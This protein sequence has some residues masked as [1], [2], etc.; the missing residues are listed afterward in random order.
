LTEQLINQTDTLN[1]KLNLHQ[2]DSVFDDLQAE[3]NALVQRSIA[4]TVFS[5]LEWQSNWWAAYQPGE[6]WVITVRDQT[7][8]LIGIAPW[9]IET[10]DDGERVIRGI[11]CVDVTD[12]VDCIVDRDCT[13]QVFGCF[14]GYLLEHSDAYDRINLCNIPH[15]SPT[16]THFP[17]VL[18]QSNFV[19]E[20]EQQEVCPVITLPNDWEGYLNLLD[21]KQRH[22]LRRKLRRGDTEGEITWYTVNES[23]DL[24]QQLELFLKLMAESAPYKAEFLRDKKN[25]AFFRRVM[26]AMFANGWL[27][28]N[29]LTIDGVPAATYLN[30]DYDKRVMVYNSGLSHAFLNASPG[31][32]LLA[33]N[34]RYAIEN[35]YTAFDFLRGNEEYKYRMG[36]SDQPVYMLRAVVEGKSLGDGCGDC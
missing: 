1:L 31:I 8:K 9:F 35:G 2:T 33:H 27:Q 20:T 30:F 34:I 22:E 36:A 17:Q 4:N 23:H 12:Y 7:D 16:Y 11:G 24:D 10:K 6:L 21:K 28:L 29:F 13:E 5:T 18:Q 3:W 26:P 32:L 19:I 25:S 15:H 14:A